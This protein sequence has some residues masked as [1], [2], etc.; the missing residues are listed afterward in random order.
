MK[1]FLA[2]FFALLGLTAS[3]NA[4][5]E[6]SKESP[7]SQLADTGVITG[8]VQYCP[9][10]GPVEPRRG[11]LVYVPGESLVAYTDS[12]GSFTLLNVPAGVQALEL[13]AGNPSAD[14]PA[15]VIDAISVEAK[16]TTDVGSICVC[17]AGETLCATG[18]TDLLTDA[19]NC[20]SCGNLCASGDQ[21]VAGFCMAL[22]SEGCTPGY[23]KNHADS[24]LATGYSPGQSVESVFAQAAAYPE[25]GSA[26]LLE[27]LDFGGGSGVDGAA[28]SLLRD[29][30]AA[31]LNAAHSGVGYP[32][33]EAEI[34]S[35]VDASLASGDTGTMAVLEAQLDA[36]NNLGCPL[37]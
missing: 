1:R 8:R 5:G 4:L 14:P 32:M 3:N 36:A 23:W 29:G 16:E 19:A 7:V 10:D 17:S 11:I 22:A 20:G 35:S 13:H 24:W 2:L 37:S 31:L 21:C 28:R 33:T 25:I 15:A 12:V 9:A 26:T 34:T 18:C 6:S 30:V 27:A